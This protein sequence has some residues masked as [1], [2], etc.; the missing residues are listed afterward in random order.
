MDVVEQAFRLY[1]KGWSLRRLQTKFGIDHSTFGKLFQRRYGK[2]YRYTK[3]IFPIV[4]EYLR[5]RSIRP[6]DKVLIQEWLC[7][8]ELLNSI[9]THQN[10]RITKLYTNNQIEVLSNKE[11]GHS[12]DWKTLFEL[13]NLNK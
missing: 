11:C 5:S 10:T 12:A 3:Q 13:V 4:N 7:G 2:N 6:R 1:L 9:I 8:D